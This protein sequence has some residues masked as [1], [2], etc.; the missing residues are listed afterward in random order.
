MSDTQWPRWEVFKQ[1]D[2]GQPHRSIGS[3]HA[4]DAEM[5]LMNARDVHVRRP[6]CESLWV[7]RADRIFSMT[8]EEMAANP[9]W[10]STF[11]PSNLQ[12]E[13]YFIFQKTS[14]RRAMTFVTHVG[15]VEARSPQEA[16]KLAFEKYPAK[17]VFVWWVCP[18]SAI[19]R[20]EPGVEESWFAPAR[21]KT[22]KQQSEYG[23]VGGL[24]QKMRRKT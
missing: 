19:T 7:A 17:D 20:T 14:Q 3:I 1:D 5:A 13:A 12:P 18:A 22:Y 11:E 23:D 2:A 15:E 8:A 6:D 21:E 24:R 16:L 9:E 4:P 10:H